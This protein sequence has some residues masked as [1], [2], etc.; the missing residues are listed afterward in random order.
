M[1]YLVKAKRANH[2]L[3]VDAD[4]IVH[5]DGFY[6]IAY[7]IEGDGA[8]KQAHI[9]GVKSYGYYLSHPTVVTPYDILQTLKET[10]IGPVNVYFFI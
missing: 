5:E 2:S 4:V 6:K 7:Y 9:R 3:I 8:P 10:F 1:K